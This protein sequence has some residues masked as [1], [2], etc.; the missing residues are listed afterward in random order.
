M[1]KKRLFGMITFMV[2]VMLVFSFI[3]CNNDSGGGGGGG[4]GPKYTSVKSSGSSGIDVFELDIGSKAGDSYTLTIYLLSADDSKVSTG[5]IT[6]VSGDVYSLTSGSTT[7]TV[8]ITGGQLKEITGSI[9]L[10]NGS[11][12]T[13]PGTVEPMTKG[14]DKTLDGTWVKGSEKVK[15]SGSSFSYTSSDGTFPG[16]ALYDSSFLV[17]RG[18][19]RGELWVV[20]GSYTLNSNTITFIGFND[21]D[22]NGDWVKQ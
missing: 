22:Y 15:F 2:G 19:Y 16:T 12:Y 14:G 8:T 4:G 6:A 5:K 17:T 21:D 13:A 18:S 7:F 20:G 3:G 1:L 11:A 9:P 10:K